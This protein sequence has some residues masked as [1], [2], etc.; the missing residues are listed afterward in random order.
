MIGWLHE[1]VGGCASPTELEKHCV[2]EAKIY[3]TATMYRDLTRLTKEGILERNEVRLYGLKRRE[4]RYCLRAR[5]SIGSEA[6]P[7]SHRAR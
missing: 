3:S 4:V 1:K 5:N 2:V 6:K 7:T